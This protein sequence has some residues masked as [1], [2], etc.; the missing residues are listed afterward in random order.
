MKKLLVTLIGALTLGAALPALAGPDWQAI[1]AAR[2]AKRTTEIS[3]HAGP[4]DVQGPTAAAS[5]PRDPYE[6]LPPTAAGLQ[7]CPTDALVLPLD[8]GPRAQTTPYQN[9][10]RKDRYEARLTAC[11][12]ATK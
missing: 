8:H 10:L 3:R 11:K 7:K 4:N 2:K 1:E 9:R 12:G 5:S 6:A